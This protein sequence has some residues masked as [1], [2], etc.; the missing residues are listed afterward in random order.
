MISPQLDLVSTNFVEDFSLK[1]STTSKLTLSPF[2]KLSLTGIVQK[3]Y[4]SFCSYIRVKRFKLH[5]TFCLKLKANTFFKMFGASK[6]YKF[7]KIGHIK[8]AFNSVEFGPNTKSP[9]WNHVNIRSCNCT[10]Y[11]NFFLNIFKIMSTAKLTLGF[12]S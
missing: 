6:N 8:K 1:L 3:A 4:F 12:G 2:W 5:T 9:T 7:H 11:G 10:K